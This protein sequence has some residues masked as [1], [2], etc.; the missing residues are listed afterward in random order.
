M[1]RVGP[2]VGVRVTSTKGVSVGKCPGS[3]AHCSKKIP[4]QYAGSVA[5][6]MK[7]KK[8]RARIRP[9]LLMGIG[10]S[11]RMMITPCDSHGK[12]APDL[13]CTKMLLEGVQKKSQPDRIEVPTPKSNQEAQ[14]GV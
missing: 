10:K 3:G 5:I 11:L 9:S 6:M 12:Y 2:G 8:M 13:G 14:N 1:K 7:I 4:Q